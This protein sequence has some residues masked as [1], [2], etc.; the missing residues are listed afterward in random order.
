MRASVGVAGIVGA[1][2]AE[3]LFN[4]LELAAVALSFLV[5][6]SAPR[7]TLFLLLGWAML[8]RPSM[9][10]LQFEVAG[11]SV[12]ELD[13]I[14]VLALA[15]A[16][17]LPSRENALSW[18]VPWHV[19]AII[20]VWPMWYAL[21]FALPKFGDT[22]FE[23][24]LVDARSILNYAVIVS[25]IILLRKQGWRVGYHLLAY[26]GYAACSIA[27]V[28]WLILA[29]GLVGP[30]S[31]HVV[32]FKALNDVR[33]GAELVV[34]ILIVLLVAG[35]APLPFRKR[36][37]GWT[38]VVAEVLVSQTL[39]I[40]LAVAVGVVVYIALR[41]RQMSPRLR[42]V[43]LLTGVSTIA[44]GSVAAFL[45]DS[46]FDLISRLGEQSAEYRYNE[47]WAV[48]HVLTSDPFAAIFGAGPG[49]RIEVPNPYTHMIDVKRDA[50]NVF[51]AVGLKTGV[52]GLAAFLLPFVAAA[53]HLLR[54]PTRQSHGL[55][56]ALI[57]VLVVS[58]TVPFVWT[59]QG[60]TAL[61]LF[62]LLC[63]GVA[64]QR[65]TATGAEPL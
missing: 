17:L 6:A 16:L 24:P 46:R 60:T 45:L 2:V 5:V 8:C 43:I 40:L 27:I 44:I 38:L 10:L 11:L 41:W 26:V 14:P 65:K 13:F 52:L 32:Y 34:M 22:P 62:L 48:L 9:E 56:G 3:L 55:Q 54:N 53:I 64:E 47:I 7:A 63:F 33:P 50:H 23:S 20:L 49:S 36:W 61:L 42:K 37:L 19:I 1:V 18:H 51:A 4:S 21:R 31:A 29:V 57:A 35:V 15:A 28:A 39:S 58:L 30:G 12:S 25:L 59:S